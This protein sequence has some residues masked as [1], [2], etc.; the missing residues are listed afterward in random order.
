MRFTIKAGVLAAV[1]AATGAQAKETPSHLT[2]FAS[3]AAFQDYLAKA[4]KAEQKRQAEQ[5]RQWRRERVQRG[6]M[7]Y[8]APMSPPPPA[9][10]SAFRRPNVPQRKV[11]PS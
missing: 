11:P 4:R 9:P 7:Q 3:E 6:P 1:M 8:P 10:A 5:E 2:P